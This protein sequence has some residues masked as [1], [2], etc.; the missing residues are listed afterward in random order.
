MPEVLPELSCVP[1]Q[2]WLS[3]QD[4]SSKAS[5]VI[6]EIPH[7]KGKAWVLQMFGQ[8]AAFALSTSRVWRSR[9]ILL[10]MKVG[11]IEGMETSFLDVQN[12]KKQDDQHELVLARPTAR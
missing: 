9:V 11:R 4:Q 1:S 5:K 7:C 10:L 6:L 2:S 3:Q 8:F 12:L